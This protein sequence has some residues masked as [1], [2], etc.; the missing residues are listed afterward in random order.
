[1]RFVFAIVA[2][3]LAAAMIVLGLAQRT[4]FL[5]PNSISLST[6]VTG[7][8]AYTVI[9]PSALAAY[10]GRQTV[11]LSGPGEVFMAFGRS[12]DVDAWIGND[13]HVDI[14]LVDGELVATDTAA[15]TD[16]SESDTDTSETTEVVDE[17]QTS[18]VGSDLWLDEFSAQQELVSAINVPDDISLIV[19]SDGV[20]PAPSEI[21]L[22]WRVDNGT[23]WAGPLI[24]GGA[25]M[26]LL[27][28]V[29]Y[30][31]ALLHLRR[32]RGPRRNV[33]RPRLPRL[34]RPPRPRALKASEITG[35]R[36]SLNRFVVIVPVLTISGLV[37]SGCSAEFWPGGGDPVSGS[38]STASPTPNSTDEAEDATAPAPAAVTVPQLERIVAKI[39]TIAT[40]ADAALDSDSLTTRFTGPALE[41]RL[42]NYKIRAVA[43]EV[44]ASAAIPAS[45]LVLTLPQQTESWPRTVMTVIQDTDTTSVAPTALVLSQETPRDNYLVEYAVQLEPE[46]RVDVAPAIVG[47]PLI[48]PDSRLLLMPPDEV[49]AAYADI[50]AQ[51]EASQWF[52]KFEATGD[53]FR[54]QVAER[55]AT[56]IAE[57]EI[58]AALEY[59]S[60]GGSGRTLALATNDSGSVIAVSLN[61]VETVSPVAEQAVVGP[62]EGS[63]SSRALSGIDESTKG[64]QSTYADQLLFYVP[65]AGS[66]DKIS[67]LG[68]SQGLISSAELP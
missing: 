21:S 34:P 17:P 28:L 57:L 48:A 59:T 35:P 51:G 36:K 24:V 4:V 31:L 64:L 42:A 16:G 49:G 44:T 20:E 11:S 27:G 25:V 23:P 30:L 3:V 46:S 13:A 47:A 61:E 9:D 1:M 45:P 62:E 52:D 8:A 63:V 22:S 40:E 38:S 5:E 26:L 14:S 2:F 32:S 18:P 10:S 65:A 15:T 37:L 66:D 39:S 33:P 6:T 68:F 50:L 67:L 56:A 29:L 43:P 7:D 55:R 58:T 41:Q 12:A 53:S 54:S 19:A 60:T